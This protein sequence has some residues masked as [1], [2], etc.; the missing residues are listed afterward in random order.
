MI[1]ELNILGPPCGAVKGLMPA[2]PAPPLYPDPSASQGSFFFSS[3]GP[4]VPGIRH[5][6]LFSLSEEVEL[7]LRRSGRRLVVVKRCQGKLAAESLAP[8]RG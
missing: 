2:P 8:L 4:F 7:E 5:I 6:C 1:K 3:L